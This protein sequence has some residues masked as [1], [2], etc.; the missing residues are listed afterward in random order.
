MDGGAAES[1]GLA[2]SAKVIEGWVEGDLERAKT[3]AR[4]ALTMQRELGDNFGAAVALVPLG[5]AEY[6]QGNFIKAEDFFGE[7]LALVRDIGN[8]YTAGRR[9]IRLGQIAYAQGDLQR[10]T[11]LTKE[12]LMACA[13]SGDKSGATMGLAALAETA[14]AR[15]ELERAARL[16][17][18]VEDLREVYGTA[19][20]FVD[21]IEYERCAEA[22]RTQLD[23]AARTAAWAEGRSMNLKKAVEYALSDPGD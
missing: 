18:A 20:W 12:G 1:G 9:L 10:A 6:L 11:A 4:Q 23:E 17:G 13:D 2:S 3:F 22:I 7:S 8:L 5:E 14:R 19:M 21:R 16:L 15:G